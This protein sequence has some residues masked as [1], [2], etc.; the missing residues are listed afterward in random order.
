MNNNKIFPLS[1]HELT[2][3]DDTWIFLSHFRQSASTRAE[4]RHNIINTITRI[5]T[6]QQFLLQELILEKLYW[7]LFHI[8]ETNLKFHPTMHIKHI[9][10]HNLSSQKDK[11]LK[12]SPISESS[13]RK[14]YVYK[15]NK[16]T[17]YYKYNYPN[18]MD[19]LIASIMIN[20]SLYETIIMN[21]SHITLTYLDELNLEPYNNIIEFDYPF[22]NLNTLKPFSY[23]RDE[24]IN[25]IYKMYY[26]DNSIINWFIS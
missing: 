21:K 20:R 26:S 2:T 16:H 9:H 23:T 12:R 22:P 13:L 10:S 1:P 17:I 24:R 8:L 18:D 4:Y 25:N 7:N 14:A 19:L 15:N 3:L 6:P 5:Y 11:I